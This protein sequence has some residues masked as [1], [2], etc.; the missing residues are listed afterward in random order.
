MRPITSSNRNGSDFA[1]NSSIQ[2]RATPQSSS[3][4][5]AEVYAQSEPGQQSVR[6]VRP[7]EEGLSAADG[8]GPWYMCGCPRSCTTMILCLSGPRPERCLACTTGPLFT[9]EDDHG[10]G[11]ACECCTGS[12]QTP[13]PVAA[14][15]VRVMGRPLMGH[16]PFMLFMLM[17]S[18]MMPLIQGAPSGD[19]TS[20]ASIKDFLETMTE[21]ELSSYVLGLAVSVSVLAIRRGVTPE[22]IFRQVCELIHQANLV[23]RHS[24]TTEDDS[25]MDGDG[26]GAD[27]GGGVGSEE[28]G[29]DS[30]R[31]SA[32]AMGGVL[33]GG[34]GE[35]SPASGSEPP[36]QSLPLAVC[37]ACCLP[38]GQ[39][40]VPSKCGDLKD[41]D[42]GSETSDSSSVDM[43]ELEAY[44]D[45][46]PTW[47][48][49]DGFWFRRILT[50]LLFF[51]FMACGEAVTCYTCY[52]QIEGCA[53]GD[54]CL[55]HS[56]PHANTAIIA[57]GVGAIT[58]ASLL[59]IKFL[60]ECTRS[61]LDCIKMVANRPQ[62]GTPVDIT[63]AAMNVDQLVEAV[64]SGAANPGDAM[65]ECLTRLA[66]AGNQLETN[67]L[68]ALATLLSHM[69][70]GASASS[71]SGG[72]TTVL[73]TYS[74]AWALAG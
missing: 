1:V 59:P 31:Y 13:A 47:G 36:S 34:V 63:Q 49:K 35:Q 45:A 39:K 11:C 61:A 44:M 19:S 4:I 62:L 54:A 15:G 12:A 74:L 66:Q 70:K 71:G 69:D 17:C 60:R 23:E 48:Q 40:A 10:G 20:V 56:R 32:F 21:P 64:H 3:R 57:G 8:R 33:M 52:D 16:L 14:P 27:G 7:P 30:P 37:P 9:T 26:G 24:D 6:Q 42:S 67:R 28:T 53:G 51:T 41:M 73:G 72:R 25:D 5:R 22:S 68:N 46:H 65:R 43:T 29:N 50:A 55:L 18:L 38:E 58:L 2:L